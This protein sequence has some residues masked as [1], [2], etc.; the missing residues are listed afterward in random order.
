MFD[1]D[2]NIISRVKSGEINAFSEIVDMYKDKALNLTMKILKNKDDAE[3]SLQDAFLKTF[4]AVMDDKFEERSKFS[5]YF[6]RIV[7]NTALDYYR[8]HISRN[9]ELLSINAGPYDKDDD[10]DIG[11][12]AFE[13]NITPGSAAYRTVHKT[14]ID[15]I[16]A[17][18][19]YII[20]EFMKHLPEKYSI[21]LT[22]FYTNGLSHDEIS[23]VLSIPLG[24]V[25]NRIFRAKEKLKQLIL[26]RYPEEEIL[27]YI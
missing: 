25:K 3:D 1:L 23:A 17:E 22:L 15:L 14:E 26:K 13:K 8:K 9:F 24:T 4:R 19:Q 18:I 6:Y 10:Q 11:E 12:M 20:N 2:I 21:I 5:T 16:N 7:Y 27:S